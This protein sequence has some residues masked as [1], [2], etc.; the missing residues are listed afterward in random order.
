MRVEPAIWR[1]CFGMEDSHGPPAKALF[2]STVAMLAL[3]RGRTIQLEHQGVS[4]GSN[5]GTYSD[6]LLT[7][8]WSRAAEQ[9]LSF[10]CDEATRPM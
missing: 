7:V 6:S 10:R 2:A 5:D 9:S 1:R 3:L 8:T 4:R